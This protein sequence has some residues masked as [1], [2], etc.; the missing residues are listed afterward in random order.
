MRSDTALMHEQENTSQHSDTKMLRRMQCSVHVQ[1]WQKCWTEN[2]G[3]GEK[4]RRKN[5]PQIKRA[6]INCKRAEIDCN[7]K[8]TANRYQIS[9][10]ISNNVYNHE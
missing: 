5:N 1:C 10:G 3:E 4:D 8:K 7:Y 9:H 6:E 2:R